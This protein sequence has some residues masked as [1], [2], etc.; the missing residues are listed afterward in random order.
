[1]HKLWKLF[2]NSWQKKSGFL[3]YYLSGKE[4]QDYIK[5]LNNTPN[6]LS[7]T[8]L[9][10]PDMDFQA[11]HFDEGALWTFSMKP[12]TEEDQQVM[13]RFT[14]VFSQTFRRYQDLQKAEAQAREAQIEAALEKVRGKAMAMHNSNDLTGAAGQ[15]FTELNNLGIKPIRCGF[16]LLSKD[17]RIAKLYPAT[18]FDNKNT[19]SFTGEFEF[20]GHIIY[21]KQYESWQKKENYFPVL[22]GDILKSYYKIL[23][24]GLSVPYENFS[25][26]RKQFGTFL[27][28]TEGFLFTWSD[29]PYTEKE[30][31]ILDRFK[32]I[33]DLTIRRY[34]DLKNAEAQS[35]ESQIEASLERVRSKAMAMHKSEDLSNAVGVVFEELDKLNLGTFRCGIG[36]IDKEKRTADA[37]AALKTD[38]GMIVQVNANESMD[39]HPLLQGAFDAW[40]KLESFSYVLKG[41]EIEKYYKELQKANFIL[42]DSKQLEVEK[43]LPQ[44]Y[45]Y[46]TTFKSG[47]LFAFSEN[48]FTEE[49]KNIMK[50][51]AEVINITYTRFL[52]LQKAE[53]QTK[54]ARIEASLERVRGKAMAM[55]SS[56]DLSMTVNVFFREL[57]ALGITPIRCG[58]TQVDA[59][60]QTS[61]VTATTALQQGDSNE[62]IGKLKM[63]GHPV[64][65]NIFNHWKLQQEYYAVLTGKELK[66]YYEAMS[67]Q[68][69][70]PNY[71]ADAPQFGSYFYFKEGYAYAW[72]ENE[73]TEE[74]IRIFRRFTS[75]ISLTY[76]RYIDL[77]EAEAQS[78]ESQIE[79]SLERVR[80]KAM[81]MQKS[82]DLGVAVATIFEELDKLNL[83]TF[84][85]GI[86]ILDKEKRT[87]DA[88]AALKT[89]EGMIVQVNTNVSMDIHPLLKGAF[90]AWLKQESY[91]YVLEGKDIEIY[92][93]ALH[94]ANFNLP[95]SK[96]LEIEK[97][98]ERQNYFVAPF[99]SG[100]LFA[101]SESE[102]SEASRNILKRFADVI[103]F[104]YSRF[105]DLKLAEAQTREAQIEVALERVRSRTLAMQKSDELAETAAVVFKQLITLGIAPTRLYI[106]IIKD[107]SGD[108]ELWATD[109]DGNK[110][111]TQFTGNVNRN[112]TIKK[113]YAAWQAQKKSTTI[114]MQGKELADYFKYLSEELKVPFKL[115]LE[116]KRRLQNIAYFSQGFI[117]MASPGD[118]PEEAI[119]LL[120][121]FAAVFNLTYTR[122][123]D[124]KLAEYNTEQAHIDL[125]KLQTEKKRAEDALT[126]LQATQTQL[127]QSEKMAS[128]GELTAG[129]A[130]EIQNPLNFVNNFSEVNAELIDELNQELDKGNF[131]DAIA[132]A[133]DIKENEEKIKHHGKRAEGIVKG[134]LQHSRTS[135][136]IKEPTNINAL[137]D[138]YLRLA[139]HGLRAKDKT[140]NATMKTDFD[141]NIG[142]INIIPQDIG[143]VILNLITNAFYAVTEKK[144]KKTEGYEPTVSVGTKKIEDKVEVR[145]KDNGNGIPKKV[146]DK[147]F[148]PFFTTKPTGQGTGLGLSLSY[149]IVKA[150]GGEL[151]VETKEGEDSTFTIQI[152]VKDV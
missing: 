145:V 39:I 135:T 109:E 29:E 59:K 90:E 107:D 104:T 4:K 19:L 94:N 121:R 92:Y 76:R 79:A 37:F 101:F 88:F 152:P 69:V 130:H 8:I 68:V 119:N 103:N 47:G 111:S 72:T 87:A 27:P 18:S 117:G 105:N 127:I 120:E 42:P 93:Q 98:L 128:L 50:R 52:D 51:F 86:G 28:F 150:H 84:R 1:A 132:I 83:G 58:V 115:G 134:M 112:S 43:K 48:E 85:C 133:R 3:H 124:L 122:F 45:Y 136:G 57:K 95:D 16:V 13:K 129:I 6:Y 96:Q 131:E 35:R 44:Q 114:D 99:R 110:V 97:K 102:F 36:I 5:I 77:K 126:E 116:Q 113:M 140:F 74:Q 9:E 70:F 7:Q 144:K 73:L 89:D 63:S 66:E 22:E 149:D 38:E 139:Y 24:E 30:F 14:A 32:G 80:S 151:K 108:V 125:V 33:L 56:E 147:I 71:P 138:E 65:E 100:G 25:T 20:S 148:Q 41:K 81:A 123:N 91:S 23:A 62:V 118:Q 75:V 21:E 12:H 64:L 34:I 67:P 10:M 17:S 31:N 141:E 137:A 49:A 146:L 106:G 61:A 78:R 2:Y 54:E 53:A 40:L 15:V 26:D 142:N 55:H 143:R 60:E 11:Y 46:I 82:D